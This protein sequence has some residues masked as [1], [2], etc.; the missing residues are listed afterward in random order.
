MTLTCVDNC[1]APQWMSR[2]LVGHFRCDRR[3]IYFM[4]APLH[5]FDNIS[6]YSSIPSHLLSAVHSPAAGF[7][8]QLICSSQCNQLWI[9]AQQHQM[10]RCLDILG[11]H[12]CFDGY[13]Q[14]G[15]HCGNKWYLPGGLSWRLST[16]GPPTLTSNYRLN[17]MF[18]EVLRQNEL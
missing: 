4:L 11:L 6:F 8:E 16:D 7:S 9:C 13:R 2:A 12:V 15:A 3:N 18:S 1:V 14:L 10:E 17:D 5:S